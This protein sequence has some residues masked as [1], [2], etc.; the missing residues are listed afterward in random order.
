[1]LVAWLV[2]HFQAKKEVDALLGKRIG[3]VLLFIYWN[4]LFLSM[5]V[6]FIIIFVCMLIFPS[7]I[8]FVFVYLFLFAALFT[9]LCQPAFDLFLHHPHLSG[10][11]VFGATLGQGSFGKVKLATI[12]GSKDQAMQNKQFSSHISDSC[13]RAVCFYCLSSLISWFFSSFLLLLLLFVFYLNY[14]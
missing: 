9:C 3:I 5:H 1:M 10:N 6:M 7:L 13:L 12:I 11:Y 4:T 2:S 14:L 8:T